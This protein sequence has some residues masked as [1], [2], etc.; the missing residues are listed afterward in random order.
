M[1]LNKNS[2]LQIIPLNGENGIFKAE[3]RLDGN[4]ELDENSQFAFHSLQSKNEVQNI[5]PGSS[6][7]FD[8]TTYELT[9]GFYT[10]FENIQNEMYNASGLTSTDFTIETSGGSVIVTTTHTITTT[11]NN[12]LGFPEDYIF[13]PGTQTSTMEPLLLDNIMFV[14]CNAIRSAI[15]N[16]KEDNVIHVFQPNYRVDSKFVE[17]SENPIF[18]KTVK[19]NISELIVTISNFDDKLVDFSSSPDVIDRVVLL[20]K[21]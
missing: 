4:L 12:V 15:L 14:R 13:I 10:S 8:G 21:R 16:G 5:P 20:L 9:P 19:T 18:Y 6:F 7:T 2:G 11:F 17:A 3:F 1:D